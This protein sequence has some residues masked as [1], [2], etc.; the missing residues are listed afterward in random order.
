MVNI[1]SK[2]HF[3]GSFNLFKFKA[4]EFFKSLYILFSLFVLIFVT[5]NPVH[6]SKEKS[7]EFLHKAQNNGAYLSKYTSNQISLR[8][9][10]PFI[11]YQFSLRKVLPSC[12]KWISIWNET[13]Y[14]WNADECNVFPSLM[15]KLIR[16]SEQK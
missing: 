12:L 10:G 13:N 8:I 11:L 6:D 16:F 2:C 15:G 1:L 4:S 7:Q 5:K 14:N 3:G 9:S